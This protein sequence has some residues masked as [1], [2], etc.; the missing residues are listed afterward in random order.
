MWGVRPGFPDFLEHGGQWVEIFLELVSL[1]AKIRSNPYHIRKL[2]YFYSPFPTLSGNSLDKTLTRLLLFKGFSA[3]RLHLIKNE[4]SY[5][6]TCG[7][8]A[9]LIA[10]LFDKGKCQGGLDKHGFAKAL[11]L[12]VLPKLE[13][14]PASHYVECKFSTYSSLKCI[15]LG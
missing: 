10:L 4:T 15:D 3:G 12:W 1:A 6:E 13:R 11:H 5:F 14:C 9:S 2:I 8:I 7:T